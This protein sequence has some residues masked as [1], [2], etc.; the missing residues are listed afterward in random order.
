MRTQEKLKKPKLHPQIMKPKLNIKFADFWTSFNKEDNFFTQL[1]SE[2]YNVQIS[3]N[4][5][6]LFYAHA[7]TTHKNYKCHKIYFTG[8]NLRPD[9]N[10]CDYAFTFDYISD[11]P[12]HFRLPLYALYANP[13]ELTIP[14]DIDKIVSEKTKFCSFIVTNKFSKDRI[15]LFKKLSK[16][17]KVD[18]GGKILN[19][20]GGRVKNKIDLLKPYK[21]NIAFENGSY[22]GYTTEKIFEPMLQNT[23]P[24]YK[25]NSLVDLD[26]NTKSFING[27][28]FE[29]MDDLVEKI[30]EVDK[31]ENLYREILSEPFFKGNQVNEYVKR[32]NIIKQFNFIF[33][34]SKTKIPVAQI[35][36]PKK[37][38]KFKN[39]KNKIIKLENEIIYLLPTKRDFVPFKF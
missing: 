33:E 39:L 17:K 36:I 30:I 8:E 21:F 4:P 13:E 28:D 26:F 6:I 11:N 19:N 24:I 35:Y 10:E 7:G 37:D 15:K 29:N 12:R 3:E 9:F 20:I 27:N 16:Y 23:I 22:P 14:K 18:S 34:D 31:N 1:L 5:D 32:N 38:E 25:G 2:K